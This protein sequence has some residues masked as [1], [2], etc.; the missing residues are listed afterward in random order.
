MNIPEDLK[1]LF[2]FCMFCSLFFLIFYIITLSLFNIIPYIPNTIIDERY[3]IQNS[4][5]ICKNKNSIKSKEIHFALLD[6]ILTKI[7]IFSLL[8]ISIV[9]SCYIVKQILIFSDNNCIT[10]LNI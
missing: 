1:V 8:N 6:Y 7:G 4:C 9:F 10:L 3:I 2:Y 5:N